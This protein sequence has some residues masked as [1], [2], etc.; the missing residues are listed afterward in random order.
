ML[1]VTDLTVVENHAR[2]PDA[3]VQ[4][5]LG[6]RHKKDLHA[7]IERYRDELEGYGGVY[8]Q[9]SA[10]PPAGSKGGRPTLTYMLTEEQ[11]VLI[12]MFARTPKAAEARRMIIDVFLRWRRGEALPHAASVDGITLD[13]D[14]YIALLRDQNALL[15]GAVKKPRRAPIPL[16]NA[17]KAKIIALAA[18][19]KSTRQISRE[20]GRSTATISLLRNGFRLIAGGNT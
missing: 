5:A 9:T 12:C 19:G 20:T 13:K 16:T 14:D 18:D 17:E 4:E 10:K 2:I 8:T 7:I 6:Y 1:A 3:R 15:K 11:A